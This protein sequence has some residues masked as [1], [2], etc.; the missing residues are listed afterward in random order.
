MFDITKAHH[1]L[2]YGHTITI[3]HHH[4]HHHFYYIVHIIVDDILIL[5]VTYIHNHPIPSLAC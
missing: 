4:Y 5:I 3:H 2:Y 1:E